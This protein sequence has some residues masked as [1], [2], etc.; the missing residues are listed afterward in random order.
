MKKR[1]RFLHDDNGAEM[2]EAALIYPIVLLVLGG[3]IYFGLFILQYVSV[4]SY[5]QKTAMLAAREVA[6]PGYIQLISADH[7]NDGA[8][9]IQLDDFS[10][11]ASS[12]ENSANGSVITIP[13]DASQVRAR[14]YR[15]WSPD[16][17]KKGA[18]SSYD[19]KST[20]EEL[21]Q[22]MVNEHTFLI[23][24]QPADISIT[25]QNYFITQTVTVEVEQKLMNVNFLEALGYKDPTV[26]VTAVATVG[27]TDEFIRTTDFVCDTLEM[28]AE[29]LGIDVDKIQQKV[30]EAKEKIGLD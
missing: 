29:K 8:I 1:S 5:A 9:E 21:L 14:A 24:N 25:C 26:R 23:G 19:A 17:L 18:F 27:D 13:N 7:I 4:S 3:L 6:Y 2:I 20:L 30:S 12:D 15:Y 28:L 16:P 10:K 11:A 22:K